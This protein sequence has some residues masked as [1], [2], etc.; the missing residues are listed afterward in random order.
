[1]LLIKDIFCF[2]KRYLWF[3]AI[4]TTLSYVSHNLTLQV[5]ATCPLKKS[6]QVIHLIDIITGENEAA[7]VK[8][9]P[10]LQENENN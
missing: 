9:W 3:V 4:K 10:K 7:H 8:K 2:I 1:M 6:C 5:L